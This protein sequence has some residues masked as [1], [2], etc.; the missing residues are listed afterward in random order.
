[1]WISA[2][3]MIVVALLHTWFMVV[4]MFLWTTPSVMAKFGMTK[5]VAESSAVLAAN[6]GLYNLF[7]AAGLVFAMAYRSSD[8]YMAV[9]T[10]FLGCIIVAGIYGGFTASKQILLVQALPAA[11]G[12]GALWLRV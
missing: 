3:L 7:L 9:S 5:E 8:M 11:L 10:F 4:E 6:Q 2:S 12:L 1:M